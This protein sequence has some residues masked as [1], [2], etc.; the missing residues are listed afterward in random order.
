MIRPTDANRSAARACP[1]A[2]CG[3]TRGPLLQNFRTAAPDQK[4][5]KVSGMPELVINNISG[6]IHVIGDSSGEIRLSAAETVRGDSDEDIAR[7]KSEVH[8]DIEQTGNSLA[9]CVNGPF[10]HGANPDNSACRNSNIDDDSTIRA[11]RLR[12]ACASGHQ[13]QAE[14]HQ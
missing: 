10:R 12:A 9:I 11:V 6:P 5:F 3:A 4:T 1:V 8:L 2:G 14:N 7:A 13:S